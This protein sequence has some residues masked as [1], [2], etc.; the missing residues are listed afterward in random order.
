[1]NLKSLAIYLYMLVFYIFI[2]IIPIIST[3]IQFY[4]E[5]Q[6]DTIIT[7]KNSY[8]FQKLNLWWN[9]R[10]RRQKAYCQYSDAPLIT[11]GWNSKPKSV[12]T[13][14]EFKAGESMRL[15]TWSWETTHCVGI[16]KNSTQVCGTQRW[17]T[18]SVYLVICQDFCLSAWE[19]LNTIY[20]R[21]HNS[22]SWFL[23][24]N[25]SPLANVSCSGEHWVFPPHHELYGRN[26]LQKNW[27]GSSA[28]IMQ[29]LSTG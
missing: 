11:S 14:R 9:S 16:Y 24:I 6:S 1:M 25:Q 26:I 15:D 21:S 2:Y 18:W 10:A 17:E 12:I 23:Y 3:H 27:N 20:F 8:I 4:I 5:R 29:I 28:G 19:P 7:F 22:P 13:E